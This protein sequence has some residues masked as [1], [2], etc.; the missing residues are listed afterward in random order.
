L[1][2]DSKNSAVLQSSE[3]PVSA[4]ELIVVVALAVVTIGIAA[5]WFV[6]RDYILYYGDAQSHLNISRGIIDS[7]T[8]GYE[9]IGSVWLPLLHVICLPFVGND[10]LWSTGLAGTIPVAAC[11][12]IAAAFFYLAARE[13]YG[14]ALPAAVT[15]A[16]FALNPN[17][18]Y[19]SS[20]P[21]T[22]TV[23]FAAISI[24]L[25]ALLRFRRTQSRTLVLV[26]AAASICASLTRYDG[27]FLIPFVALGFFLLASKHRFR[28][29]VLFSC[30][31]A[32][33]PLYWMAHNQWATADALS[34]YRGPYSAKGIYLR[35][36]AEGNPRDPVDHNLRLSLLYYFTAGRFCS[37][38]PLIG[39]GAA[40][41]AA[42]VWTRRWIPVLFLL[43]TPCFYIWSMYST[44][45]PIH[46]PNLWPFSYYNT[47]YGL[48]LVP[49]CGFAAGALVAAIPARWRRFGMALPVIAV[50]PWLAHPSEQNW[51]CWHES[52]INSDSRR[53][54]SDE[55]AAFLKV[56]YRQGDG[57]LYGDGDVPG[58]FCRARLPLVEGLTQGN[59]PA[60]LANGYQPA[61]VPLSKWAIVLDARRDPL[62]GTIGAEHLS[63]EELRYH[64]N[65]TIK[66][67]AYSPVLEI[68]TEYDPVVRVYRRIR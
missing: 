25:F 32:L 11:F 26:A 2:N 66:D 15:I 19:L 45:Q 62:A 30:I 9:Q 46:I 17:M 18:L 68:H 22:E 60:Y 49:L 43:L 1:T 5:A 65:S 48:A 58:A 59:G 33:A 38:W 31:A 3:T 29:A 47:R 28:M 50:A 39:I 20:I 63:D 53:F 41:I 37:G 13:A 36:L 4:T 16:C 61:R 64:L 35:G 40:G 55:V 52:K 57:I 27:W 7:R 54:W 44:G 34:F 56:N 42:A 12:V 21:M 8:P 51:I 10:M 24:Q 14:S 67:I 6:H 23:F